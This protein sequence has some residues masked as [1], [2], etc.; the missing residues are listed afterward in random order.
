MFWSISD[1]EL[2]KM[3]MLNWFC[4]G[5]SQSLSLLSEMDA[6]TKEE[7]L[8]ELACGPGKLESPRAIHL[9]EN[10]SQPEGGSYWIRCLQ[11]GA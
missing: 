5:L 1:L 4:F 2:K 10:Q 11:K 3:S 7:S 8:H 6:N 9:R